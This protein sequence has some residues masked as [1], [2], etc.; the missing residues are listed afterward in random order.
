MFFFLIKLNL[1]SPKAK[2]ETTRLQVEALVKQTKRKIERDHTNTPI[3]G[4]EIGVN[5][6]GDFFKFVNSDTQL[7]DYLEV[8][9]FNFRKWK[10]Y[11]SN[12]NFSV[13]D[14]VG[15]VKFPAIVGA[16]GTGKVFLF[17]FYFMLL[18]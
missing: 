7:D 16:P 8:L 3:L 10:E 17:K 13:F 18:I 12:N 2:L 14:Y 9:N 6:I 1:I 11:C 15:A 5:L 4:D